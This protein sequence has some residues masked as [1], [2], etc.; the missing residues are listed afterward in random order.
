MQYIVN[1]LVYNILLVCYT[2]LYS[3]PATGS[4]GLGIPS[5]LV[6]STILT[7]TGFNTLPLLP[8]LVLVY[9]T[10]PE[11]RERVSAGPEEENPIQVHNICI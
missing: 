4:L 7:L 10:E 11:N 2:I 5:I 8:V 9:G 6:D 1:S 3:Y